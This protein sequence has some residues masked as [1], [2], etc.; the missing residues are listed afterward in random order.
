MKQQGSIEID[1]PIDEVFDYTNNHVAEW[2]ITVVED[3]LLEST[4]DRVGSTFRCVTE[5]HGNH[6]EFVGEVIR[7]DAP[8]LSAVLLKAKPFDIAVEYDFEDLGGRTRVTQKSVVSPKGF[9]K[10]FFFFCGWMFHTSGCK[11]LQAELEN[12]KRLLE[13]GAG[14]RAA[15]TAAQ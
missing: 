13:G 8:Y 10:V 12:L 7:Y 6:V 9:M 15:E 4:P 5:N 11:A 14:Q 1:R 2:S 3:E